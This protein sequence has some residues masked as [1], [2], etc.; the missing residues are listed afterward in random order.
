MA[1]TGGSRVPDMP[2]LPDAVCFM[3]FEGQ[4]VWVND[5]LCAMSGYRF[6]EMLARPRFSLMHPDD[7]MAMAE[8]LPTAFDGGGAKQALQIRLQTSSGEWKVA[9]LLVRVDLEF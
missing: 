1:M 7:R 5:Q 8:I 6:D 2:L 9:E 3:T 4:I